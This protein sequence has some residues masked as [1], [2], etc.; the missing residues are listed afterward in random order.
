[1]SCLQDGN[2][3]WRVQNSAVA[4]WGRS[5]GG[6]RQWGQRAETWSPQG[7]QR[8]VGF[9]DGVA[10][11]DRRKRCQEF[12]GHFIAQE[13]RI[14]DPMTKY[15][16]SSVRESPSASSVGLN[17]QPPTNL[18]LSLVWVKVKVKHTCIASFVKLQLKALRYGSHRVA[19]A[20]YTIPA[21]TLWT[22]ARWRHHLN[23][24]HLI[25]LATHLST[26]EGW[27]AELV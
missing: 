26:P 10:S 7:W 11:Y 24:R 4:D 14:N 6:T 15:F 22:F 19:P 1:M 2:G 12:L 3:T 21:S 13:A 9:E 5:R 17:P 18:A 27:K 23:G 16:R 8:A 25:Q 20:N